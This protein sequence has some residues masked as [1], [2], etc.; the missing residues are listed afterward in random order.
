[1]ETVESDTNR[2]NS[3]YLSS[4]G[5][6][7]TSVVALVFT[8]SLVVTQLSSRYSPR[9]LADFF[10]IPT[11]IF[12]LLFIGTIFLSFGF[13]NKPSP[14]AV[15]ISLTF[16]AACLLILIPYFLSFRDRLNPEKLMDDLKNS[17]VGQLSRAPGKEPLETLKTIDNTMMSAFALRD[18]DTFE[19]GAKALGD[20]TVV[21]GMKGTTNYVATQI[22]KRLTLLG[23]NT[24]GDN[25]APVVVTVSMGEAGLN[26]I[27]ENLTDKDCRPSAIMGHI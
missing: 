3:R 11:I 12:I 9:L 19:K 18:Y 6:S 15:K 24:I 20:L 16:A 1:M 21:A 5:Q 23:I 7:L 17:A 8:V 4:V 25:R 10:D 27:R 13:L 2:V 26:A 14:K 22:L